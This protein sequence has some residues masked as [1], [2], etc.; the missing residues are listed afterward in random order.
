MK[1]LENLVQEKIK[2]NKRTRIYHK[3]SK[4]DCM[5]KPGLFFQVS[6]FLRMLN[7]KKH[8]LVNLNEYLNTVKLIKK[9]YVLSCNSWVWIDRI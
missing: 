5:L 6:E 2:K 3:K 4:I 9:I 1:P 7:N 8:K